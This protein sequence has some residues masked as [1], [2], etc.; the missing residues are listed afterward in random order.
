MWVETL[1]LCRYIVV[2]SS[3]Y[4]LDHAAARAGIVL[5]F[6]GPDFHTVS[7]KIEALVLYEMTNLVTGKYVD[8]NFCAQASI[9]EKGSP[10]RSDTWTSVLESLCTVF[11]F[12]LRTCA[13]QSIMLNHFHLWTKCNLVKFKF[14]I[15]T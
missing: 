13:Q 2:G 3:K 7:I 10:V 8:L 15:M 4:L 9:P 6:W 1:P 5:L 14:V 12:I 11:K